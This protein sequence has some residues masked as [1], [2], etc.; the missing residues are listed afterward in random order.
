MFSH[1][2]L[3]ETNGGLS[4]I[5][6]NYVTLPAMYENLPIEATLIETN[7]GPHYPIR[8]AAVLH[9]GEVIELRSRLDE[10]SGHNPDHT[11]KIVKIVHEVLDVI[12]NPVNGAHS[13]A[14]HVKPI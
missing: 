9:V 2:L 12:E 13:I 7:D 11:Y 6:R 4:S 1:I 5:Y 8:L 14:I 10:K 3:I